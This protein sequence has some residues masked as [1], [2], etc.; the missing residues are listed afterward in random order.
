[1]RTPARS[2]ARRA[3]IA[4]LPARLVAAGIIACFVLTGRDATRSNIGH[5]AAAGQTAP[6]PAADGYRLVYR[7]DIPVSSPGYHT[8]PVPYDV[9]ASGELAAGF[10]RVGY[11]MELRTAGGVDEWVWASMTAFTRDVRKIGLP[12]LPSGASFQR[13]VGAMTVAS[14]VPGVPVGDDVAGN[15]EFW[16][17]NY[18]PSNG[19]AVP[20]ASDGAYDFGDMPADPRAGYGSL[21]V[22]ATASGTTLLAYNR[23]GFTGASDIGIGNSPTGNPDWTFR[24]NAGDYTVRRLSVYVREAPLPAI[25]LTAPQQFRVVQRGDDDRGDLVVRGRAVAGADE[26][27][28]RAVPIDGFRGW[29]TGDLPA[30]LDGRGMFSATL[31]LAAGWYRIEAAA[32]ARGDA[33]GRDAVEPVGVGEVFVTAGQSNSANHGLPRQAPTDPRVVAL[34]PAGWRPAADPQ[35]IATGDG[36]SPWPAMGDALAAALGVPIGLVSVGWGGTSVEQWQPGGTLYPRLRDALATLEADGT[37]GTSGTSERR[38][39]RGPGGPVEA[40]GV[41]AVLWHQG[42]SDAAG[43]TTASVY[44]ERLRALIRAS[45]QDAGADVPWGVARV[46]FVPGLAQGP[47]DAIVAGQNAVIAGGAGGAGPVDVFAG[48]PTDD[49]VGPDWRHDGIH[50]NGPGLTEHGRRWAAAILAAIAFPSP[51]AAPTL[52]P[53]APATPTDPAT[54]THTPSATPSARAS[55]AR[56]TAAHR[57]ALPLAYA[58]GGAAR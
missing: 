16:P 37:S 42:E 26:V 22:H 12:T 49:L 38:G 4:R 11:L 45:R 29:A 48:P 9:D 31:R 5:A 57:L 32:A 58:G 7:L 46:G 13:G 56:P 6:N 28:V 41:R 52:E 10:D 43:G 54:A 25:E 24:Q 40:R 47:I 3:P 50:F 23:W 21:Q 39:Q 53:T 2:S 36:G 14:N 27:E 35:P 20:G 17:D 15:I 1:M 55:A 33:L 44:A 19:A 18:A 34:G 30:V 51:A 8:T